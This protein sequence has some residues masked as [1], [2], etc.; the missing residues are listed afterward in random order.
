[1]EAEEF[2]SSEGGADILLHVTYIV[3]PVLR[4]DGMAA[5]VDVY[6][7]PLA[8]LRGAGNQV[9]IAAIRDDSLAIDIAPHVLGGLYRVIAD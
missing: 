5:C 6:C 8:E 1:M 4:G 2:I 3:H 9:S 7:Q